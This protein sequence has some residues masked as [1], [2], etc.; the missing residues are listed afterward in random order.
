MMI[1]QD[2]DPTELTAQLNAALDDL[3][4]SAALQG[5]RYDEGSLQQQMLNT[6]MLAQGDEGW[7]RVLR[8]AAGDCHAVLVARIRAGDDLRTAVRAARSDALGAQAFE[9]FQLHFR[10]AEGTTANQNGE[11]Q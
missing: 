1:R 10:A 11:A 5:A 7:P 2:T 9:E 6:L 8:Q 4:L 3:F